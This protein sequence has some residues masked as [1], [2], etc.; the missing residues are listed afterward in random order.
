MAIREVGTNFILHLY[1]LLNF[2]KGS[3]NHHVPKKEPA[4]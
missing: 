3:Q 2:F 4:E 1:G